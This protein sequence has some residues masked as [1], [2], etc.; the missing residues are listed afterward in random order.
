M[1]QLPDINLKELDILEY[2][3]LIDELEQLSDKYKEA[4]RELEGKI[5]LEKSKIVVA[6][7]AERAIIGN[8]Q[9]RKYSSQEVKEAMLLVLLNENKEFVCMSNELS[10]YKSAAKQV[11]NLLEKIRRYKQILLIEYQN[12][13]IRRFCDIP[14]N[15]VRDKTNPYF[16]NVYGRP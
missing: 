12:H 2:P 3:D 6:L 9:V 8:R 7:D 14:S 15:D 4:I 10:D 13:T 1:Y 16:S 11:K 5:E